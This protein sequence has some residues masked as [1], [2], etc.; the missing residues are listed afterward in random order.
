MGGLMN[1]N[2]EA[3]VAA[4]PDL[5]ILFNNMRESEKKFKALGIETLAVKHDTIA[6]ILDSIQEIGVRCGKEE[7]ARQIGDDIVNK[8]HII[9]GENPP[10]NPPK[11]LV[12]IGHDYS[13]D[14]SAKPQNIY[15]AGNDGFYSEMI[16]FA[17][18]QNAYTGG[19]PNPAV[20]YESIISM[21]PQ[22]IIDI[23]PPTSSNADS[24]IAKKQWLNLGG[25]DAV[26]NKRIYVFTE[27]YMSIPGPRFINIIE[28]LA[29]AINPPA[30]TNDERKSN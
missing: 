21:N 9:K 17:G 24:E 18:G 15:L 22:V 4:K 1:P 28:K 12:C 20:S 10:Q 3:I 29:Q 16:K 23:L 7:Q 25:I 14:P 6:D 30:Q 13:Q 5:V 2:Y 8:I 19:I 26:K 27:D 11:V